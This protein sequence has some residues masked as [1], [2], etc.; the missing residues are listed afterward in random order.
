MPDGSAPPIE[1]LVGHFG[2]TKK[3]HKPH[4]IVVGNE[5]GGAGKSTVSMHI[6]VALAMSGLRIGVMDLDVRQKTLTRYFENREKW[7]DNSGVKLS[8]PVLREVRAS[9]ARDKVESNDTERVE[10]HKHLAAL[11]KMC[12]VILVDAPGSY[13]N[14]SRCAHSA[15]DTIVTPMND[16]FVDFDLLADIDVHTMKI[17]SPSLYAEMVWDCRKEKARCAGSPIDWMVVRNRMSPLK[18]RNNQAL[19][20]ALEE[21]AD[22]ISF[23]VASGL[24]ERVIYRELFVKGLTLLDM[25]QQGAMAMNMSHVAARQELRNLVNALKLP[26]LVGE[27]LGF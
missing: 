10:F 15:A 18:N 21:L 13:T 11:R 16:S 27:P 8:S 24:S 17:A 7:A 25:D 5:K 22:R 19:E 2:P 20:S 23:R 26:A 3:T 1:S 12:D 6:S 4:V 14:L 9:D